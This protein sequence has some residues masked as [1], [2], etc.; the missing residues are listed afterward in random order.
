MNTFEKI[1]RFLGVGGVLGAIVG[2]GLGILTENLNGV[3]FLGLLGA[4]LGMILRKVLF[5][6]STST[7]ERREAIYSEM[8]VKKVQR[9]RMSEEEANEEL[10]KWRVIAYS[11]C[12]GL[13]NKPKN[14]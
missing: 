5:G 6:T 8:L 10:D 2:G 9:G 4:V 7:M 12:F 11:K 14:Q 3:I 13:L 1:C